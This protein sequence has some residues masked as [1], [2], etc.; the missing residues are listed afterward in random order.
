VSE[1]RTIGSLRADKDVGCLIRFYSPIVRNSDYVYANIQSLVDLMGDESA[2][3]LPTAIQQ[4]S[5]HDLLAD[6]F[7]TSNDESAL[8]SLS[9]TAGVAQVSAPG[10]S[11][12]DIM[13]LF[14]DTSITSPTL[15]SPTVNRRLSNPMDSFAASPS[16]SSTTAPSATAIFSSASVAAPTALVAYDAHGLRITLSPSRDANRTNVLNVLARFE[17]MG[18]KVVDG[19]NFQAA[20]PKVSRFTLKILRQRPAGRS[21][22]RKLYS[23]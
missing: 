6:I 3:A 8:T 10:Q 19:V 12:Q 15:A 4:K 13:G 23:S 9:T 22:R 20:V 5:A 21:I 17:A 7:G 2:P 18:G 1:R 11:M 14:G 16:A